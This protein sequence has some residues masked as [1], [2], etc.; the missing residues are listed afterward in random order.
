MSLARARV[1]KIH[2]ADSGVASL[3]FFVLTYPR[4]IARVLSVS[5]PSVARAV[6]RNQDVSV[7]SERNPEKN[8]GPLRLSRGHT[9]TGIP[10]SYIPV[11]VTHKSAY[12]TPP[13]S[14]AELCF[15]YTS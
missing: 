9:T 4:R 3:F 6:S 2:S 5:F 12:I 15:L 8:H 13:L 11:K 7:S 14:P 10:R 1:K